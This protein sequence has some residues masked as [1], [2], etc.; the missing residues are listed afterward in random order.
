MQKSYPE[1]VSY[2]LE[3]KSLKRWN[4][5]WAESSG[6]QVAIV[7]PAICEFE[8]IKRVLLSLVHNDKS[9][10]EK[11]LIIFVLNNSIASKPEVK[12]DNKKSIA[13]L[14][15]MINR[16]SSDRIA[17]IIFNSGMHI[18]LID[19]AAEGKEF[20]DDQGGVG[21][22][23]KVGMDI[24]LEVFDYSTSEKKLLI[25]LDT[26]CVVEE[27]YLDEIIRSF[28]KHNFSAATVDFEHILSED[29][30]DKLGIISY[31]IFL[32]HLVAGLLFAESPYAFHTIGSTVVCDH[33]AYIKIGGMN[34]KKAAEDFYFLQKL[35]KHFTIN[36]ISS[37]KVRPS[38]RESWRVPFGTGR[39]MIDFSTNKKDI[40]LYD[41]DVYVILKDWLELLY[42]DLS[43][44]SNLIL[45]EAKKIHPEL[46]NFL[47]NRGFSM[48]WEKILENSKSVKQ[49]DYQ[50]KNW[51]DAF[52]TLKLIHHLRNTSFPMIDINS[53]VEKLFKVVQHSAKY[54]LSGNKHNLESLYMGYLAELRLLENA[55]H[56]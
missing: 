10:L 20:D 56:K 2:Y 35:A 37:T 28:T 51:F 55:L 7:I 14:R 16:K 29:G 45:K 50:R 43:L 24:A 5:E 36:R 41:A 31:E 1:K 30:I 3:K 42:S 25:S 4:L 11:S 26:D 52:E 34:T 32:R 49:L 33:E 18:G 19:A 6:I 13:F 44:N 12:D 9:C 23:R 8:N 27:N 48:D 15:G 53:G 21:L 40:L 54:E 39:S 47:E 38:A 17:G 22:A 46:Y